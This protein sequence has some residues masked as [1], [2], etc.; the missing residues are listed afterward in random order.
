MQPTVK[1]ITQFSG[2]NCRAHYL[3]SC[4]FR[5][6]SFLSGLSMYWSNIFIQNSKE[7]FPAFL[8]LSSR[9]VVEL[10]SEQ[11]KL[12]FSV[13][14]PQCVKS[15]KQKQETTR[16]ELTYSETIWRVSFTCEQPRQYS[17]PTPHSLAICTS[18]TLTQ[19]FFS[20][21]LYTSQLPYRNSCI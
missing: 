4:T 18:D 10:Q 17:N 11:L 19:F 6:L 13:W 12:L 20:C 8:Q 2:K 3:S 9:D 14:K 1:S 15:P 16:C 21:T 5:S 7:F